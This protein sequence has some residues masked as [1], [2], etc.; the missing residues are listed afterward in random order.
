MTKDSITGNQKYDF[1]KLEGKL[2][3]SCG[4][5]QMSIFHTLNGVPVHSVKNIPLP[6]K[7]IDCPKG[8]IHLAFCY[9]CGFISNI[10]FDPSLLEYS[11]EYESSQAFSPTFNTFASD[12]AARLIDRFNLHDKI[13]LEIGCGNG[14]FLNLLCEQGGNRGIG[15]DP[16]YREG[17]IGIKP[18]AKITFIKDYYSEKYTNYQADFICCRMTLEHIQSTA[19]FVSM[20][21]RSLGARSDAIIFFQVP[22]VTRILRDCAIEDIYFEHC[23]YFS[24]GSLAR[25]FRKCD[26]NVLRL[27]TD[28]EGQY[29]MIEAKTAEYKSFKPLPMENDLNILADYISSFQERYEAKLSSWYKRLQAISSNGKHAVIWGSGSKGVAFLTA[30]GIHD[31]IKYVVDINP[32]RQGT[33][34]PGTGQEIVAPDFLKTYQ[35][36]T[37][38]VMNP[39]YLQEI[40]QELRHLNLAP[41]VLAI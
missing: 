33:F 31:E 38:I 8:N 27:E 5:D 41:D 25:L 9:H 4:S 34:M 37:V 40:Q 21:R 36:E 23:S 15:F 17:R 10:A 28:Y 30:L 2:C 22:D 35:P 12:L 7:A 11:N 24:P 1:D 20:V 26:F 32:N 18:N 3:H 39:I 29:L 19:N 13:I 6:E 16:A 14:E